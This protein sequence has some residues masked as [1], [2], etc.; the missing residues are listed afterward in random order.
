MTV[1]NDTKHVEFELKLNC[2]TI[3]LVI[4]ELP[5]EQIMSSNKYDK[6]LMLQNSDM[7]MYIIWSIK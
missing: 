5:T 4:M 2:L 7:Y 6:Q 1:S 3:C